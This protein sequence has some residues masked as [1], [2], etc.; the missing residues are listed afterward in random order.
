MLD[1]P[2]LCDN[3]PV[4]GRRKEPCPCCGN[5]NA[6]KSKGHLR[7]VRSINLNRKN[8]SPPLSGEGRYWVWMCVKC[9]GDQGNLNLRQWI[10]VLERDNDKRFKHV[11][12]LM[13]R[14]RNLGVQDIQM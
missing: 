13:A 3:R 2:I 12:V 11:Q 10:L 9:N 4:F 14:L 5:P 8:G 1:R 7:P 6:P